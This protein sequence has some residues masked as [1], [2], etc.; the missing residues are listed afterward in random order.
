MVES[1]LVPTGTADPGQGEAAR[2]RRDVELFVSG[3]TC[4]AC[5]ARTS[6]KL[7]KLSGVAATVNF[8][9]GRA[10][11]TVTSDV[12]DEALVEAVVQA[13][14]GAEVVR[15]AEPKPERRNEAEHARDL[16]RR[17]VVAVVLFVPL[18]DLSITFTVLPGWRFPGWQWLLLA[19]AA[20]VVGWAAAP[21]HRVAARNAGRGA[22]SMDTLVSLGIIA[23]TVWSCYSMFF[24]TASPEGVSGLRLLLRPEGAIYLEVA[25]GLTAFVLAGRY[26]EAKARWRAG[27]ALREL[28]ALR[29]E[30]VVLVLDDGS[31]HI[32]PVDHL[33]VG[34]RFI[35]R[36]GERIASDGVV[37]DGRAAVDM[38]TMTG[39]SV[40][41]EAAAGADVIGGTVVLNGTLLVKATKVGRDTQLA[42]MERLVADAQTGEAPVQRVADRASGYFVPA[43]LALAVLTLA[44]WLLIDGSVE[45]S[46]AAAL[47]VLVI[48][49][50]CALGLA[51]PMALMVAS[52]RAARLG[53]FIK[54]YPALESTRTIDTVVLD[55]TGTVTTG[56]MS[57][58]DVHCADGVERTELLRLVGALEQV[59]T[60]PIAVAIVS[61]ARAE[62]GSLPPV[63]GFRDEPG[64]GASGT[65][66]GH[67]VRAGRA[68]LFTDHGCALPAALDELRGE[69]ERRGRTTVVVSRD[70][71]FAGLLGLRDAVRA[72]ARQAV[73]E[74]H[75]LGLR[76]VLLTG[77]N[78]TT[79][80]A[81]AEEI[82]VERVVAG[83]LP[84]DKAEEVRRLRAEGHAV[85]VVGD[86]VNDA[87]ALATADLGMAIGA[88]TD[89]AIDAAD[90]ILVREDVTAVPDAIKLARATLRT[91]RGNLFWAFG[92]NVAAIPLAAAGLL[93]PLVA[94]AAMAMSSLFVVS[95]SMRLRRFTPS[96]AQQN[97]RT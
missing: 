68:K 71:E 95:N 73:A 86:G 39:E 28:A 4:A 25:A 18:A 12:T 40:P 79:A 3:M 48:A 33:Q 42:A 16:W 1:G 76:T 91:I 75:E 96:P 23:A 6:R 64:L 58:V 34:R 38:S 29:A 94:G 67:E 20:P 84:G 81:V 44:G 53:L 21:F 36:S 63:S 8:A 37:V 43:V 87:P 17:L 26:F 59:S 7:N 90:L 88:G 5:A 2:N 47:A 57:L 41:V 32:V 70:E 45:R 19:L 74:L 61:A 85:A 35:V 30:E 83:V 54:G 97:D 65:V 93:N 62:V 27:G 77:D 22:T 10:K 14:Y 51:T 78:E 46:F 11:V 49:C 72:D 50:P 55:K 24:A 52:G 66:D 69:W 15:L 82:G 60:H 31:H 56:T 9:T 92:Y 80:R 89:V 13:G